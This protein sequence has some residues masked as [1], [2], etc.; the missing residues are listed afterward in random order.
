[1]FRGGPIRKSS[2]GRPLWLILL[3]TP[4][5]IIFPGQIVTRGHAHRNVHV[6]PIENMSTVSAFE[7]SNTS[8]SPRKLRLHTRNWAPMP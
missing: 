1:M 3:S 8:Y 7:I 4:P 6:T 2:D 5:K